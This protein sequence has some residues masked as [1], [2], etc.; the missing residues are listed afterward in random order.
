MIDERVRLGRLAERGHHDFDTISSILD[1]GMICHVGLNAGADPVVFPTIYGRIERNLYIHGSA[2]ARWMTSLS[3]SIPLCVTV[4]LL[5]EIVLARSAYQHSLNYRS[6]VALGRAV[7]VIDEAE[8]LSALEAIV[9]QVC[10]GRWK[11]VRAP[12]R[13]ELRSTL[14]L[15]IPLDCASAK[16]RTGPPDDFPHDL[17]SGVW[18]GC[19]PLSVRRDTPIP[20]PNLE[21]GVAIPAYLLDAPSDGRRG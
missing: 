2:I 8:K 21:D 10:R 18:A 1:D 20:A 6:V 4:S 11:D 9:E 16:I 3:E 13:S 7:A 14:V 17:G 19:V 15:R 5:D 12:Q